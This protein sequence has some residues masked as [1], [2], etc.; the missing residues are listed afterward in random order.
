PYDGIDNRLSKSPVVVGNKPMRGG[1]DTPAVI[2]IAEGTTQTLQLA[3]HVT[4]GTAVINYANLPAWV[5]VDSTKPGTLNLAPQ[6][7]TAL[8][9]TNPTS[10]EKNFTITIN[11]SSSTA[12]GSI[13]SQF[14]TIAVH[15]QAQSLSVTGFDSS[16]R[17]LEGNTYTETIKVTSA[18]FPQGP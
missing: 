1:C 5:T 8:D 2:D 13:D 3:C 17:I 14:L 12:P 4:A 11:I 9:S 7:G 6:V 15:H 16:A 10:T 18:D